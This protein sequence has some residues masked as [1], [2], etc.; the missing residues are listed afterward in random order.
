MK[1]ERERGGEGSARDL[2]KVKGERERGFRV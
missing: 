1:G 2:D